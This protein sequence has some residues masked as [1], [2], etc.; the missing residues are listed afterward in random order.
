MADASER[1]SERVQE[2]TSQREARAAEESALAQKKV[3]RDDERSPLKD[4]VDYVEIAGVVALVY[5]LRKPV[6]KALG[7]ILEEMRE[8]VE[9]VDAAL[10]KDELDARRRVVHTYLLDPIY[11]PKIGGSMYTQLVINGEWTDAYKTLHAPP[12]AKMAPQ[13][14]VGSGTGTVTVTSEI[15]HLFASEAEV[16]FRWLVERGSL[17]NYGG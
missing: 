6:K 15:V 17:E 16:L 5:A 14:V 4:I 9:I 3:A 10:I 12:P 2:Q 13:F 11:G 1:I 7:W 8:H